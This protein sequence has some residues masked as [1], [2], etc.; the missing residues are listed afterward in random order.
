MQQATRHFCLPLP[1][2]RRAFFRL[3]ECKKRLCIV[4]MAH[5]H[6]VA[7]GAGACGIG[8]QSGP[9]KLPA[10]KATKKRKPEPKKCTATENGEACKKN[11]QTRG[12]CKKHGGGARCTH[13]VCMEKNR[14]KTGS[15]NSAIGN[16]GLCKMHGGGKRTRA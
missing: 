10:A 5:V 9:F 7:C 2:P 15:G 12:L 8:E 16:T 14:I 1:K 6:G 3:R 11:V 13:E 4:C